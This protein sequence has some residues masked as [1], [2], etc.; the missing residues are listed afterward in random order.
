MENNLKQIIKDRIQNLKSQ[1]EKIIST[2]EVE[3]EDNNGFDVVLLQQLNEKKDILIDEINELRQS[4]SELYSKNNAIGKSF[5]LEINGTR[6]E[7]SI[8]SPSLADPIN[9]FI[10]SQS[11]L[12]ISLINDRKGDTVEVSTPVG[13]QTYKILG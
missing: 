10:S 7:I 1:I 3:K 13:M 4:L 11:P 5:A 6:K 8:V 12:A 2:I 9:G